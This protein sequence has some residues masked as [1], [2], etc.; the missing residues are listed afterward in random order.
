MYLAPCLEWLFAEDEPEMHERI[1]RAADAGFR[2]VEF[3][4]WQTRDMDAIDAALKRHGIGLA[5]F[6]TEPMSRIVDRATHPEFLAG[7][8]RSAALAK[9]LGCPQLVV[10]A[11]EPLPGVPPA[12]QH[13]AVVDALRAAGPIARAHGITL[14]LEPLNTSEESYLTSTT[15]GLDIVDEVG[16]D[17]VKLLYDIYHSAWMGE[18]VSTVLGDRTDRVAHVQLADVPDRHEPGTGTIDWAAAFAWLRDHGY[19]GPVGL[20]YIPSVATVESLGLIRGIV[21]D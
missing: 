1:R 20:E 11:G 10:T 17:G 5:L 4:G 13:A 8:E 14:V 6:C 21:P 3:W 16:D 19:H 2:A 12:E 15:E 9:R 18:D 7:V